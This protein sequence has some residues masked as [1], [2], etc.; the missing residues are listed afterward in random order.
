MLHALLPANTQNMLKYHHPSLSKWL[1]ECTKQELQTG[2]YK[3]HV[4]PQ[5]LAIYQVCHS[6]AHAVNNGSC[7]S[8][9]LEW[10]PIDSIAWISYNLKQ[11]LDA[12]K[13]VDVNF[14]FH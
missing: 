6:I 12:I 5:M 1:T 7:S 13:H 4:C 2:N 11:M 8:P 10:K 3:S 9:S 14:V